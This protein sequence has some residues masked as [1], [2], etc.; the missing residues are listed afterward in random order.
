MV[1]WLELQGSQK[2]SADRFGKVDCIA[3]LRIFGKGSHFC[4]QKSA[5][6]KRMPG[7]TKVLNT[8]SPKTEVYV[9]YL[10][11]GWYAASLI[12]LILNNYCPGLSVNNLLTSY[13]ENRRGREGRLKIM[14]KFLVSYCLLPRLFCLLLFMF[15][16]VPWS[17]SRHGQWET[18][19][20]ER[21]KSLETHAK[22]QVNKSQ[23]CLV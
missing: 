15:S 5:F 23:T 4:D 18:L 7:G 19:H 14:A 21:D 8:T 22:I 3:L 20:D 2:C 11:C 1:W 16:P 6:F 17:H 9:L 12:D 10:C 13:H